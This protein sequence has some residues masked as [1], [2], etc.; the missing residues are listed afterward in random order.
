[1]QENAAVATSVRPAVELN[2]RNIKT[3]KPGDVLRDATVKGLQLR[4]F[5]TQKVFYLYYRTKAGKERKPKLDA[6]GKIT[7]AQAREAA[8]ELLGQVAAGRD[9]VAEREAAQAEHTVADLWEEF[10]KRHASKKKSSAEDTRLWTKKLKDELGDLKMSEVT[11][12]VV[13]DLHDDL[14]EDT[15]ISANRALALLSTMLNFAIKPLEWIEKNAA[16][17]VN[18]NKEKKRRRYMTAEEAA[19]VAAGLEAAA[20]REPASAA[21]LWLLILTG[22]R[23]GELARAKWSDL[24]GNRIILDEHK[25]DQDGEARVIHLNAAAMHVLD[26]LPRT[27]GTLTGVLDLKKLW[28]TI[29]TDAGCPDLR[30]HDLRHSFASMGLANGLTLPQIGELLGHASADTTKRD[31]HLMDGPAQLAVGAIGTSIM[32]RMTT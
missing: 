13:A 4:C 3:A 21:F 10:W 29:R 5:P 25:T 2:E 7:L 32:A 24:R 11:Y 27:E 9:P 20:E 26:Q 31:A 8:R 23:K 30:I 1:M 14:T 17:G 18:R 22:A 16:D 19:K 28:D 6:Y 15:P 12:S